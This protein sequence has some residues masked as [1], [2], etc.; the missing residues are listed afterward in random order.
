MKMLKT[1]SMLLVL[2]FVI[3]ACGTV[4]DPAV[5]HETSENKGEES[6]K[7]VTIRVLH[8]RTTNFP[9]ENPV[10]SEIIKRTGINFEAITVDAAELQNQLNVMIASNS[11]PDIIAFN[12]YQLEELIDNDVIIPLD[13]LLEQYGQEILDNKGEYLGNRATQDGQIYALP[14]GHGYPSMLALRKDWLD[15]AGLQV[16]TTIDEYYEVLKAF[17][18]GDP[19]KSGKDNTFGLGATLENMNTF[20]HIF[21]AFGV[22]YDRPQMI[23]GQLKPYILQPGYLDAVK[24]IN[25]LYAEGVLD[26]DFAT[27]PQMQ[28]FERLW[29]G[30]VG[31]F[32]FSPVGTSNNWLSRYTE[33]QPEWVFPIIAGPEGQGGP[34]RVIR[35][36][37]MF[38][39]ITK[40]SKNPEEAMKLLNF[41][42]SEEG[43]R[44]TYLGIEGVHYNMVNDSVEYIAPY[45]DATQHR[46]EGAFA[47]Y[48]I[49]Y[50]IGGMEDKMLNQVT[51]AAIKLGNEKAVADDMIY[52]QPAVEKELGSVLRNLE[53]EIFATLAV[54]KGDLD[55]EYEAFVK[56][57][58]DAGGQRWVEEATEIYH[59]EHAK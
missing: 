22:T 10:R 8:H 16:P 33:P 59:Q 15:R 21:S 49:S 34:L 46:N 48:A 17:T 42:N 38:Y 4:N 24:F 53:L 32:D 37:G 6:V 3:S 54:S 19:D 51:Q 55:K 36:N 20:Q 1:M 29:N 12:S 44:L 35:D 30:N 57:Y 41:L 27:I 7:P 13:Q 40:S 47:Y 45:D 9:E 11:L 14:M 56:K 39:A 25:K 31:A 43:D 50:R 2:V 23:D 5:N 28:A 18:K 52:G 58:M 26:P